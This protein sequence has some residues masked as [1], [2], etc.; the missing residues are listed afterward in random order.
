MMSDTEIKKMFNAIC[1]QI[2]NSTDKTTDS[3]SDSEKLKFYSYYKQATVGSCKKSGIERP[4]MFDPVGSAKW[5]AWNK[6]GTMSK[7]DAMCAYC[8]LYQKNY[9]E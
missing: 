3:I 8:E 9:M 6:L 2:K 5:D 1:K 4:G 7:I